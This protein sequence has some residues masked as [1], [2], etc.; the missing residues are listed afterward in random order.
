MGFDISPE[1]AIK[2][3]QAGFKLG[4]VPTVYTN[5]EKGVPKFKLWKM[6]CAYLTVYWH[7]FVNPSFKIASKEE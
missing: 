7:L 3:H 4:E 5:R 6:I 1:F 2:A